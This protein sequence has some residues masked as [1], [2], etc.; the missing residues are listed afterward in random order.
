M[1]EFLIENTGAL[2]P[3]MALLVG[4]PLT[5]VIFLWRRNIA[6]EKRIDELVGQIMKVIEDNT[7]SAETLR[8]ALDELRRR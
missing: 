2:G 4:M 1:T 6:L 8:D 3:V 7:K 5:A